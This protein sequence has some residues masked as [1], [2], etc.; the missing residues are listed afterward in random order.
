MAKLI[1]CT[2][3]QKYY[4]WKKYHII[5]IFFLYSPQVA[6]KYVQNPVL[7]E[8]PEIGAVKFDLRF[9]V[10]MVSADPLKLYAFK[11]FWPRFANK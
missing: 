7:F 11:S 4:L 3:L 2:M 5:C 1:V 6:V 10:L 8:W 9:H